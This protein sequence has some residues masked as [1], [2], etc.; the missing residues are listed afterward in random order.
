MPKSSKGQIDED[1]KKVLQEL[2][3]NSNE[4]LDNIA[5]NCGFSRQ[6]VWRMIKRL[7]ENKAIWGYNTVVDDEKT[8]RK[9]YFILLK[10]AHKAVTDERVNSV[11]KRDL[12]NSATKLGVELEDSYYVNGLYDWIMSITATDI[13][14]VKR[15]C[16]LFDKVFKG[17]FLSDIQILEVLFPMERNGFDNPNREEFKDFF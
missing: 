6:K 13:R 9:R 2:K 14:Q 7:E 1:E 15:F 12:R 3:K 11:V 5:K 4:S 17:S 10:R 8:G 16:S